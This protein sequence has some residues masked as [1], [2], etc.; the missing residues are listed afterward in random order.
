MQEMY[1]VKVYPKKNKNKKN[2]KWRIAA[3][4]IF[5]GLKNPPSSSFSLYFKR[6]L[7]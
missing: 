2:I 3:S 4:Q 5:I 6:I 7:W 1:I